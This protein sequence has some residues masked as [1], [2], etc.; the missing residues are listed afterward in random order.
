LQSRK[1]ACNGCDLLIDLPSVIEADKKWSCPR[2]FHTITRGH[3]DAV[4]YALAIAISCLISFALSYSFPFIAFD[5]SGQ[6]REIKL[7]QTT[8]ELYNQGYYFLS[9]LVFALIAFLPVVY[10]YLL[11]RILLANILGTTGKDLS[12]IAKSIHRLIPWLMVDVFLIGVLV[13]L[14]KMWGLAHLSFGFSFW[15]YIVFVI[16]FSYLLYLVDQHKLWQWVKNAQ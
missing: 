5:V 6:Y 16:Q 10:L 8:L 1:I 12:Y 13:A 4:S 15:A 9:I 11:I 14:I 2:C 7:I 3:K